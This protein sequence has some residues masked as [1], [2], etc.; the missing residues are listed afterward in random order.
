MV[1]I[2]GFISWKLGSVSGYSSSSD[3]EMISFLT[4]PN[5]LRLGQATFI[6]DIKDKDGKLADN[7]KV[8]FDLNMTTMNMGVQQGIAVPQGNGR[9]SA[10]G[11]MTMRGPWRVSVRATLPDGTI[12]DKSFTIYVP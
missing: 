3:N 9:Y 2:I 1:V 5:P 8:S 11:R 10:V 12:G 7:A 6:F 4:V